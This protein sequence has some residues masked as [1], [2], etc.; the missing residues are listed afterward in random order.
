[1]TSLTLLSAVNVADF[2]QLAI[3]QPTCPSLTLSVPA[4]MPLSVPVALDG[5][6]SG[7]ASGNP[8]AVGKQPV[9]QRICAGPLA[10]SDCLPAVPA[11]GVYHSRVQGAL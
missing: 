5:Y 1:M 7:F 10:V 9:A 8:A 2:G 4:S 11:S 6:L 3:G